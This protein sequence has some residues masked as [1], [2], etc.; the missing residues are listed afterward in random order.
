MLGK[1][2]ALLFFLSLIFAVSHAQSY[3]MHEAAEDSDGGG[4]FAGLLGM[5]L[6]FGVVYI[7]SNIHESHKV[8]QKRQEEKFFNMKIAKSVADNTLEKHPD[9]SIYQNNEY[10]IKGFEKAYYDIAYGT[11]FPASQTQLDQLLLEYKTLSEQGHLI[12]ARKVMESIGYCQHMLF[13]TEQLKKERE[14]KQRNGH[15]TC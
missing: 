11:P 5:A 1:K 10:W 12:Q 7:I 13:N 15:Y 6:L 9:I 14:A 8:S 3:Y 2:F 4:P